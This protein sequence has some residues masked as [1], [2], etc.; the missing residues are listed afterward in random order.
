MDR[1]LNQAGMKD[2]LK[3][4]Y[5]LI[6]FSKRQLKIPS[7]NYESLIQKFGENNINKI[8]HVENSFNEFLN[9]E[10]IGDNFG[11]NHLNRAK[12]RGKLA[13]QL[14]KVFLEVYADQNQF[15][16]RNLANVIRNALILSIST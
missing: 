2:F 3:S 5:K 7:L 12:W 4:E 9:G 1:P 15:A 6:F 16:G 14:G 8:K 11:S 10:P 13:S